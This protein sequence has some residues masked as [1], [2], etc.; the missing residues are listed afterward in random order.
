[1]S[2]NYPITH[3]TEN[4]NP[5]DIEMVLGKEMSAVL[6]VMGYA[7]TLKLIRD[8][9]GTEILVPFGVKHSSQQQALLDCLNEQATAMFIQYFRGARLYIPKCDE[10]VRQLRNRAF[11]SIIEQAIDT[12]MT[13]TRAIKAFVKEFG[14]TERTAYKVI[15]QK[16]FRAIKIQVDER[17]MDL[18]GE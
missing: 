3:A 15:K 4:F 18:F 1:M 17:Q 16:D 8:F 14:I 5:Q 9:G 11:I 6:Q 13:K 7:N 12:G 2:K 10:V